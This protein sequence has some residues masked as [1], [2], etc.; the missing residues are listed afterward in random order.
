MLMGGETAYDYSS[1]FSFSVF[2]KFPLVHILLLFIY[3]LEMYSANKIE[4]LTLIDSYT[5]PLE[6]ICLKNKKS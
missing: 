6:F 5:R 2:T 1:P 3:L 4:N